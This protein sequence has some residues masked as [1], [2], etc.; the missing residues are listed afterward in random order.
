[1]FRA[2]HQNHWLLS[3]QIAG[4]DPLQ[5]LMDKREDANYRS[6]FSEP[7]T[8]DYMRK[9]FESGPRRLIAEYVADDD[10]IY[11]FDPDHAILAYPLRVL[12]YC[13]Q[14]LA[15]ANVQPF[16]DSLSAFLGS[17]CVD[18]SGRLTKLAKLIG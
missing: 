5:W 6:Q 12:T 10:G 11:V 7:T 3:Q 15:T 1:M 8:P 9:L 16:P 4:L 18:P 17:I 13:R 2:H 14:A